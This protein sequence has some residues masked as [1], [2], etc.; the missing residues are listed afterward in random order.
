MVASDL[1]AGA[2]TFTPQELMEQR[3]RGEML[4]YSGIGSA[5]LGSCCLLAGSS[6]FIF[7]AFINDGIS[8]DSGT[9]AT[10]GCALLGGVFTFGGAAV[11]IVGN[12]KLKEAKRALVEIEEEALAKPLTSKPSAQL[13]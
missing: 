2:I 5:G 11:G 10:L 7:G 13:Y 3:E 1:P 8:F 12:N 6:S 9:W 4:L